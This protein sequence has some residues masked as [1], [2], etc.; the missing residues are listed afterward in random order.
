MNQDFMRKCVQMNVCI[1][2]R[3]CYSF[4]EITYTTV[5]ALGR[6]QM[7]KKILAFSDSDSNRADIFYSDSGYF[8]S[9]K[10]MKKKSRL[11]GFTLIEVLVSV[12]LTGI[13]LIAAYG[14]FQGI[15]KS[16]IRLSGTIDI[17]R[18][19]FYMNEKIAGLIRN[20]G[21][22]DYEEYFNRRILGYAQ[23]M[24]PIS[25]TQSIWTYSTISHYGNGDGSGKTDILICGKD[26]TDNTDACLEDNA[27][28][29]QVASGTIPS[30]DKSIIGLPSNKRH[31]PYGQY[32]ELGFDYSSYLPA[33]T[34]LPSIFPTTIGSINPSLRGI[35]ELYLIKKLPDGSYERVYFRHIFSQDLSPNMPPCTDPWVNKDGCIGKLQMTKLRSCDIVKS[36]G[37]AG[38]DGIID[39]WIPDENFSQAGTPL[40]CSSVTDYSEATKDIY[41][42][43]ISSPDM[44]ITE[45]RFLPKPLKIPS[46]MAGTGEVAESPTI[47]I[48]LQVR[49]SEA[50][51]RRG[52]MTQESNPPRTLITTFD[53]PD[54]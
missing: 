40:T 44:N 18:N 45:A 3:S 47:Q 17:Q 20:G 16:Q 9:K 8:L 22:I 41:W 49:L 14:A 24:V 37:T 34:K 51:L 28:G 29:N 13:I 4:E 35:P 25:D 10:V 21:T 5:M 23:S 12:M 2:A 30:F 42:V 48:H 46:L 32:R 11:S 31:Q 27:V 36:W 33:P 53:L 26:N 7:T 50:V 54:M 52:L 15:M 6:S 43:D 39:V 19:L 1:T 38:S